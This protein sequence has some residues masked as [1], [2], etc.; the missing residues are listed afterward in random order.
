MRRRGA[1]TAL[2]E[3]LG[4]G[5]PVSWCILSFLLLIGGAIGLYTLKVHRDFRREDAEKARKCGRPK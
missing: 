1:L 3:D 2:L 5:D 4:Q